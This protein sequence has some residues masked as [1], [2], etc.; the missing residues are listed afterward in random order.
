MRSS[1]I[2]TALLSSRHLM[3]ASCNGVLPSLSV[4]FMSNV[5]LPSNFARRYLKADSLPRDA[6]RWNGNLPSSSASGLAPSAS[7]S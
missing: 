7:T 1:T 2:E 3:A 4:T 5:L 6:A